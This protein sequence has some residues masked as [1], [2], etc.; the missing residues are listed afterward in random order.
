MKPHVLVTGG[1]G[2]IGSLLVGDLLRRGY[3]VTV[4][5]DCLFG[6]ESLLAYFGHPGFR[7]VEGDVGDELVL[8]QALRAPEWG[9]PEVVVH[10]AAIV[11]FPACQ[12]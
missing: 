10:L 11:G 8:R 12:A 4:V 5:D 3:R 6:A 1:A 2:Y 9:A 7:W